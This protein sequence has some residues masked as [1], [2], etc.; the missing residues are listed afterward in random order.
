MEP[1]ATPLRGTYC[2][3]L[4][5]CSV[6]KVIGPILTASKGIEEDRLRGHDFSFPIGSGA[7]TLR[8][9]LLTPS[10]VQPD[11]VQS[12]T[13]RLQ[14]FSV[15]TTTGGKR[16]VAILLSE[17]PFSSASGRYNLDGLLAL[18]V[19]MVESLPT[20]LPIIP[21]ADAACF[22]T[23]VQ[24]YISGL[25]TIELQPLIN[26]ESPTTAIATLDSTPNPSMSDGQYTDIFSRYMA[27]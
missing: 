11:A 4:R 20:M 2:S 24:E 7:E 1:H 6:W 15:S 8:I 25:E 22:L 23:S 12:T 13:P 17:A 19:L 10:S 5:G 9:L 16:A 3:S 14:Q 26:I 21:V 18:Q 27:L